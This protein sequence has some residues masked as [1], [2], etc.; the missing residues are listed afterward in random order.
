MNNSKIAII[1]DSSCDIPKEYLEKHQVFILP[2]HVS[3]PEG[4]YLDGVNISPQEVYSRMPE[5]VPST[6]QPSPGDIKELFEQL[7]REGYQEAI[8]VCI[9]SWTKWNF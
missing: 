3:M 2:L 7:K 9:S 5:V 8:A 6:S 4:D 1:T